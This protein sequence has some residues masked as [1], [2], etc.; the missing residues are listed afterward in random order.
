ME[1][2]GFNMLRIP[3]SHDMI[4]STKTVHPIAYGFN[5]DLEGKT[6]MEILDIIINWC[7]H[8]GLRVLLDYHSC[9]MD[10]LLVEDLWYIPGDPECTEA[11]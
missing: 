11:M 10:G 7:A 6:P 4:H 5:K 2:L 9:H 1:D 8:I 3:F